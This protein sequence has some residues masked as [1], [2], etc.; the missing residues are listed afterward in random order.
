MVFVWR[1]MG[2]V[3][4]IMFLLVG[5]IVT[6]WFDGMQTKFGNPDYMQWVLLYSGIILTLIG[7]GTWK[8]EIVEDVGVPA[9]RKKHDFFWIPILIWGLFFLGLS[10]Y[11]FFFVPSQIDPNSLESDSNSITNQI[12]TVEEPTTRVIN[13]Y[14]PKSDSVRL[15]IADDVV[16]KGLVSNV[17]IAPETIK[18][19]VYNEGTYMFMSSINGESLLEFPAKKYVSDESKYK[20]HEDDKGAFYQRILSPATPNENDYDEAWL[21]LDGELKMAVVS[22]PV[23]SKDYDISEIILNLDESNIV[24]I[25][26]PVDLMEPLKNVTSEK[27]IKVIGPADYIEKSGDLA[28]FDV[29]ALVPFK[30]E[31]VDIKKIRGFLM[32]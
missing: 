11:L 32:P 15:I 25:L 1:G 18:K 8:G 19:D 13:F 2:I 3:V 5:W 16:A 22:I 12:E 28:D 23:N 30:T 17:L 21:M 4:P 10:I 6:F 29:Y 20:R 9:Y 31:E 26:D 27:P 7:L 24:E 14:N